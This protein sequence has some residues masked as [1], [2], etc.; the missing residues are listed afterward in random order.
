M[1]RV[2]THAEKVKLLMAALDLC[3]EC[4]REF[5]NYANVPG[6]DAIVLIKEQVWKIWGNWPHGAGCPGPEAP[7]G[8]S[9]GAPVGAG[10]GPGHQEVLAS[11][12]PA[13]ATSLSN[14]E[15]GPS[16]VLLDP[17]AGQI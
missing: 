2:F 12:P 6:R 4:R 13:P 10:T 5:L 14:Q 7:A 9:P 11:T 1:A 8:T 16:I 17:E 15:R 3:P